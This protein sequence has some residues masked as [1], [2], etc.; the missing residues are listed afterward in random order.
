MILISCASAV[1]LQL[2]VFKTSEDIN[3]FQ[4]CD[5]CSAITISAITYPNSTAFIRNI[6]MSTS[7]GVYYNY[8]L[9][10]SLVDVAGTYTANG[11]DDAGSAFSYDFIVTGSGSLLDESKSMFYIGVMA[12]LA[13]FFII[14]VAGIGLLPSRDERNSEGDI[15]SIN[16]LKHLRLVFAGIAWAILT[17]IVFL[18]WNVAEGYL[19]TGLVAAIF[20]VLFTILMTG[21]IVGVPVIFVYILW[22]LVKENVIKGMLSR[23]IFD[24]ARYNV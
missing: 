17:M 23:N 8:T 1:Q 11:F 5:A 21:L 4:T 15:I 18:A 12:I 2:G 22:K 19:E 16:S 6:T 9:N 10:G 24:G 14:T 7:D 20:K 3:L 13:F